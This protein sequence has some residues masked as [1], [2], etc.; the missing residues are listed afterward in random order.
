MVVDGDLIDATTNAQANYHHCGTQVLV[1]SDCLG[2]V[3]VA[4]TI[5]E[6]LFRV[7]SK[8]EALQR[9]KMRTYRSCLEACFDEGEKAEYM[10][11]HAAGE[12]GAA[13]DDGAMPEWVVRRPNATIVSV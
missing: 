9:H 12:H 8:T 2:N 6:S 7:R 4:P 3:I 13:A 5:M 11:S 10:Q 1:D